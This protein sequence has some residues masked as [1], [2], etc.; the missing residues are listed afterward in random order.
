MQVRE[1]LE[2]SRQKSRETLC[3]PCVIQCLEATDGR[4][5]GSL[6]RQVRSHLVSGEIKNSTLIA[7]ADF[8]VK[9]VKAL[10]CRSAFGNSDVDI[11]YATVVRSTLASQNAKSTAGSDHY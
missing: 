9:I 6:K 3:F 11:V 4:N 5:V 2:K 10:H 1:T 7:R 8:E